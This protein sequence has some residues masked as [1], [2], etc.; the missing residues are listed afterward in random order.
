LITEFIYILFPF[1]IP[2][3]GEPA[4]ETPPLLCSN[5]NPVPCYSSEF[6]CWHKKEAN[7]K[8]STFSQFRK[9]PADASVTNIQFTSTVDRPS[10][11]SCAGGLGCTAYSMSFRNAT[12]VVSDY[13]TLTAG[14]MRCLLVRVL[15]LAQKGSE[16]EGFDL[17]SVS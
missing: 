3:P 17:L 7:Q 2:V 8:V 12:L 6:S 9:F 16:S 11:C 5:S 13:V 1:S 10:G 15:L 4:N 14:K